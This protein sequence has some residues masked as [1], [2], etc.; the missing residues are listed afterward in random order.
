M[1]SLEVKEYSAQ[2]IVDWLRT[3]M[4]NPDPIGQR[5]PTASG[6]KKSIGIIASMLD[7][8][9]MGMVTI[10]DISDDPFLRTLYGCDYLVIDGGHRCRAL[11][12]YANGKLVVN[13]SRYLDSDYNLNDFKIAIDIR[14]CTSHEACLLFRH[15]N[16]TTPTNFMEMIMAD[17]ISPNC[18]FIRSQTTY[19]KEY[20]NQEPHRLFEHNL[21]PKGEI[22]IAH[23][24][25]GIPNHR[26]KWDEYVA[27]ACIRAEAKGI[28]DAGQPAIEE[29]CH[30]DNEISK[31]T[32][33]RVNKF[34]DAVADFRSFNQS[35]MNSD[36]MGA[37]TIYYFGLMQKH[38][39][40]RIANK[41]EFFGAFGYAHAKMTGKKDKEFEGIFDTDHEGNDVLVKEFCRSNI[42]NHANGQAQSTV[43]Y[44]YESQGDVSSFITLMDSKR[45]LTHSERVEALAA[46]GYVCA[47]DGKPLSLDEA[48]FGHDT[49]WC[50]GGRSEIDNGAMI[51]KE[52]NVDMGTCTIA[53]YR[54]ILAA[55]EA[56]ARKVA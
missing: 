55:R 44:F 53:E 32:K 23:W 37:F 26:R 16:T 10:R 36:T 31:V 41:N 28:V 39:D 27:I 13:G 47:I 21:T 1:K 56:K 42:K 19:V 15:I 9:G 6:P 52:H 40:F 49:P 5:P 29:L 12:Q 7:G 30:R 11:L 54:D 46:Q 48:V 3:G 22:K 25:N 51:R 43:Y 8:Y 17:E 4:L 33:D 38:G 14:V 35:P 34:L 2:T 20:E 18:K 50:K 45:S 24:G